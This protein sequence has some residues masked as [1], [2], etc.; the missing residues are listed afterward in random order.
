VN[1]DVRWKQRFSNFQHTLRN[2][3]L[4]LAIPSPDVIQRAGMVQFFEMTFELSWKVLKDYL[5]AQGFT[6]EQTPRAV[7]K[8]SFEIGLIEDGSAWLK[9]LED[10]NLSSH[11]YNEQ[12][13]REIEAMISGIYAPLFHALESRLQT[14]I[15]DES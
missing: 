9:G 6:D 15:N 4:A 12:I 1:A 2:L 8:K 14:K 13:A 10:R 3:D 11:I 5:E 7:I